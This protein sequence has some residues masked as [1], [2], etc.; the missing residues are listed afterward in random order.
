MKKTIIILGI[1]SV[2]M[3]CNSSTKTSSTE[4]TATTTQDTAAALPADTTATT[5]EAAPATPPATTT[6]TTTTPSSPKTADQKP[7]AKAAST[8]KG[9]QL[10]A[11]SDCLT[12]H[13]VNEKLVGPAYTAVA[14]KYGD[15]EA[16][17]DYLANKI[18][19]G[20]SGVWGEIPMVPHPA[21]SK[22]DAKE[23]ARYVL[24]LK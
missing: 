5:T 13:K 11:K 12:C 3:A 16:N 6:T 24:S 2:I 17:I 19:S 4:D 23:M 22:D 8:E 9:Q 10:V 7:A 21:V 15:T 18:I 20:G 14:T 1:C